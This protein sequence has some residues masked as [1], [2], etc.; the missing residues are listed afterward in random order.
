MR[1]QSHLPWDRI[2]LLSHQLLASFMKLLKGSALPY[3][4]LPRE[5]GTLMKRL[6]NAKRLHPKWNTEMCQYIACILSEGF[7]AVCF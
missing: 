7:L 6:D 3:L 5:G 1:C 2:L 4:T